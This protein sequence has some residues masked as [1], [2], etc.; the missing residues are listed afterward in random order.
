VGE[1]LD[2]EGLDVICIAAP[3]VTHAEATLAAAAR[4]VHVV[5]E[6]PLART[7]EECD[8]MVAACEDA[9]VLLLYAEQLCFAP[10][11]VRVR[12]LLDD[13]AFGRVV[14]VQHRERHGGPHA[15]WFY[16]RA[17]SGG[18]VLLDMG[19]HGVEVA[20][21]L[22]GKPP[23]VSVHARTG[24]FKHR[25]AGVED[26]ALLS[27]RFAGGELAL[28]DAS[29]AA[30]GG[31]DERLEVLGTEGAV[32]ADLA[33]GQ[34][35]LVYTDAGL[36]YASEKATT[37]RG[38]SWVSHEEA[39]TWGWHAEFEHFVACVEGHAEPQETGRDGRAVLEVVLAAYRSAADG[40]EIALA[41][42]P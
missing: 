33:R 32:T 37:T 7:L 9:G 42:R 38:W 6:K 13:G 5:C 10:R 20:R 27:L 19:C 4:G 11:Y 25:D 16:D 3:N 40:T 22:L 26:H 8:A 30:P 24:T 29:W 12:E 23:V 34:S 18:G 21:W 15:S 31:I 28:I 2:R 39:R 36:A 17:R 41:E 35:L 14:Q 1:L